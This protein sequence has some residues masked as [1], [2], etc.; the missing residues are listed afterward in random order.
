MSSLPL[1]SSCVHA[2]GQRERDTASAAPLSRN[3]TTIFLFLFLNS[4]FNDFTQAALHFCLWRSP[5]TAT[6][7]VNAG[8]CAAFSPISCPLGGHSEYFGWKDGVSVAILCQNGLALLP[9]TWVTPHEPCGDVFIYLFIHWF[10]TS[11]R[12]W[13]N[14]EVHGCVGV[15]WVK[16]FLSVKLEN[17]CVDCGE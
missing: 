7:R 3:P 2:W 4:L 15:H 10:K 1:A 13:V 11:G 14:P 8:S 12:H 6:Q 5:C 16:S 17:G 9:D